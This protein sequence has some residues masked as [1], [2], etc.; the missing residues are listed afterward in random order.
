MIL[1]PICIVLCMVSIAAGA[2]CGGNPCD[3]PLDPPVVSNGGDY[4]GNEPRDYT[5]EENWQEEGSNFLPSKGI[6]LPIGS[7]SVPRG[8]M[9]E[10][11][12]DMTSQGCSD[13]SSTTLSGSAGTEILFDCSLFANANGGSFVNL[14]NVASISSDINE[15]GAPTGGG[16]ASHIVQDGYFLLDVST[17]GGTTA[18]MTSQGCSGASS[19]TLSGSAGPEI[20][21]DCSLLANANAVSLNNL[22]NVDATFS[23][24]NERDAPTC[25]RTLVKNAARS[26]VVIGC[27]HV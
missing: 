8:T 21:F 22:Q 19:M 6:T 24:I 11:E 17:G 16:G 25:E 14:Q 10:V 15:R 26:L 13:A 4:G 27:S 23:Y 20:T 3:P 12:E 2:P 7:S 1:F 5:F 9:S 18:T